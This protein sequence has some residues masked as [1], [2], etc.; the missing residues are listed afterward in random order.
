[1]LRFSTYEE[2]FE[3]LL[4]NEGLKK[5]AAKSGIS[6][7]TL[8]KVYN[9]G[10]A[11]WRTGHRPGTTP[12]QW[13]MARVNSYITKGKGTYYGADSDLSGKGKKKKDKKEGYVSYA[14][15]K[16]AHASMAERGKKK[17]NNESVNEAEYHPIKSSYHDDMAK[18]HASHAKRH[19]TEGD[20][21][22]HNDEN[23]DMHYRAIDIH[24]QA[25]DAH[26]A[27]AAAASS[28]NQSK[29]KKA[30][31]DAHSL[32]QTAIGT[33]K[34]AGKFKTG[35]PK[36][37]FPKLKL[38]TK[39]TKLN[40]KSESTMTFREKL[41][42]LYEG[43]RKAHYKGAT[44]PE[45]YDEKQKSSKGA[46]DMLKTPR[47]TEADGMK[48]AKDTAD[49]I[50]KSAPG[51]KMR[52]TDKN[53]GDLA[54]KPS[55]TPVKDPA[56]KTQTMESVSENVAYHKKMAFTHSEHGAAH[57]SEVTNGGSAD[58]DFASDHHHAAA[59]KHKEAADAHKKHGGDSK[60]Y[61]SA[62]AAA[63]KATEEA[64]E[65]ARDA[66]K[67]K[68]VSP[69]PFKFPKKPSMKKE[70]YGIAGY[71]VSDSLLKAISVVEDYTHE[72]DVDSEKSAK[73]V[74]NKAKKNGIKAKIHT[75]KGPGGGNPV[76]HLGHKDTNHMH[77]FIKKHYDDSYEKSDLNM[78]KL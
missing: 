62:A 52:P 32:S 60:Q 13:G 67:I 5:K 12:Q 63:H 20:S 76:V 39:L 72:F 46:M 42:S 65:T 35:T 26:K 3:E 54:I 6:Y 78:H 44:P 77:K 1:M 43:D 36:H 19:K 15:Q 49:N 34:D 18:A 69:S 16:A 61:K 70:S 47:S 7:G 59:D 73:Y 29:Y 10:M 23:E 24:K 55:A 41:M 66:G 33:T 38:H 75:M 64:H 45:E 68:R 58:H 22:K 50:K 27:A 9:R 2:A 56:A 31:K 21:G 25:H 74:V 17:K 30:A 11:A 57:E 48:A 40:I 8:K 51:K 53:V 14:Q 37:S 28:L 71:K 4:E